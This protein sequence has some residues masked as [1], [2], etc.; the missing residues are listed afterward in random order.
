MSPFADSTE[1]VGFFS[2]SREDDEA[3]R[4]TLSAIR[5]AIQREL[6]A[7]LG[8]TKATFRLW[9]DKEAIAPGKL[10]ESEIKAAVQQSVFFIPI[11]TPRM[12]NSRHCQFEFDAFLARE[13]ELGRTDLVFPILYVRVP[14]LEDETRWRDH[15]VLSAIASRQY[16]DWQTFRHSD[17]YTPSIREEIA[18]FAGKIV[19]TLSTERRS[20]EGWRTREEG[21]QR[22]EAGERG[23]AAGPEG[24]R[25]A[26][27]AD[28]SDAYTG[29]NVSAVE[30]MPEVASPIAK[31]IL[32]LTPLLSARLDVKSWPYLKI[33]IVAGILGL[34]VEPT[35]TPATLGLYLGSGYALSLYRLLYVAAFLSFITAM[36]VFPRALKIAVIFSALYVVE[37]FLDS[38]AKLLIDAVGLE[39]VVGLANVVAIAGAETLVEWLFVAFFFLPL[40]D[41][42][43]DWKMPGIA[44]AI[45]AA[46]GAFYFAVFHYAAASLEFRNE[47][48][49]AFSWAATALCLA[50][51][52][53]RHTG[54]SASVSNPLSGKTR[55]SG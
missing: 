52:I 24:Q 19:D 10:W 40:G 33:A 36:T 2:Y 31:T 44:L 26:Y 39:H 55:T 1:I 28:I 21:R 38:I 15:P 5:E 29:T 7:Q 13:R 53:R 43:K 22:T 48:E 12:V 47:A 35:E 49:S 8:R 9:Q 30:P 14:A 42:V 32:K 6:A 37:T 11:V 27:E 54:T 50:Y 17:A 3:F 23:A 51:G 18:R 41:V 46:N 25:Q 20:P 34:I 45:G 4:G 16:V